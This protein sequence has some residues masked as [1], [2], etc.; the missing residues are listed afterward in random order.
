MRQLPHGTNAIGTQTKEDVSLTPIPPKVGCT[1]E[2]LQAFHTHMQRL[3]RLAVKL[4][5]P[6][7]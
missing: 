5:S 2:E 3:A 7:D 1:E 6:K 4:N